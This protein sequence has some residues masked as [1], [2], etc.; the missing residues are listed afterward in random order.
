MEPHT[1]IP[2]VGDNSLFKKMCPETH[3]QRQSMLRQYKKWMC[4]LPQHAE[5]LSKPQ[6]IWFAT[7]V[8]WS[9]KRTVFWTPCSWLRAEVDKRPG[10]EKERE[11]T[12]GPQAGWPV[13]GAPAQAGL[14]QS[15]SQMSSVCQQSRRINQHPQAV[16]TQSKADTQTINFRQKLS[17][18]VSKYFG[19]ITTIL[20]L[21][22]GILV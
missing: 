1:T 18:N 5:T 10:R 20:S 22:D 4:D 21:S 13:A 12:G 15:L 8:F 9:I 16:S 17:N 2:I 19:N 6:K 3:T 14:S 11:G 7:T